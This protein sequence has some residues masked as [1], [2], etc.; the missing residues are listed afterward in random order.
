MKLR[1]LKNGR[2]PLGTPS[3]TLT[4]SSGS[5]HLRSLPAA[6]QALEVEPLG[7]WSRGSRDI[8]IGWGTK[9]H[10]PPLPWQ[11][12]GLTV[13]DGG[14]LAGLGA[15]GS[16]EERGAEVV[17]GSLAVIHFME[18]AAGLALSS[19]GQAASGRR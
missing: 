4:G 12:R 6:A 7:V 17:P 18:A 14:P 13:E 15:G 19:A 3:L 5:H 9:C 2:D 1:A 10:Q 8:V 16:R 11:W